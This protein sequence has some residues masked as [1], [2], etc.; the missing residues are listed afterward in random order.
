MPINPGGHPHLLSFEALLAPHHTDFPPVLMGK[1]ALYVAGDPT[2]FSRL[3]SWNELNHLVEF[4]GLASPRLRMIK[5]GLEISPDLFLTTGASGHPRPRPSKV[6]SELRT[7]AA[8]VI[9]SIEELSQPISQLCQICEL[10]LNVPVMADLY[11]HCAP[12]PPGALRWNEHEVFLLQL[13]GCGTWKVY[14]P[15]RLNPMPPEPCPEPSGQPAWEGEVTAGDLLYL[16]RG[17]WY[18]DARV[19]CTLYLAMKFRNPTGFDVLHRVLD[20]LAGIEKIRGDCPRFGDLQRQSAFLGVLQEATAQE[21]GRAGLVL[22]F[23]EEFA[24]MAEPRVRFNLPWSAAPVP[25]PPSEDLVVVP[26]F[27]FPRS[28]SVIDSHDDNAVDVFF[29][30]NFIRFPTEVG[31]ILRRI[32]AGPHPSL[33][34]LREAS[35]QKMPEDKFISSLSELIKCGIVAF[36]DPKELCVTTDLCESTTA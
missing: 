24:D 27:R 29:E 4:G 16:P 28:E 18:S 12:S 31:E 9:Q 21:C 1:S 10:T 19:D 35:L 25:L 22:S 15:T 8:L 11:A 7:G 32:C 17:W 13:D 33:R 6:N 14:P 23:L 5:N 30:G 2:K 34:G 36:E 3:F 26:L 20:G